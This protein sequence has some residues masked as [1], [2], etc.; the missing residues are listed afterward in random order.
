MSQVQIG[1]RK[2][3]LRRGIVQLIEQGADLEIILKRIIENIEGQSEQMLAA[4]FFYDPLTEDL[5]VGAAPHLQPSYAKAVNGFKVGPQQ[6]ACGSAV[7]RGE[8]VISED[9]R[10]D[11]LWK[12]LCQFA[13]EA[14][15]IAVWSEPIFDEQKLVLGTLAFYFPEPKSPDSSDLIILETASE[16]ASLAI[17]AR[18]H[19]FDLITQSRKNGL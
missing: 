14:K 18:R 12:N 7:F 4:I 13:E 1:T 15:I 10:V 2:S 16:L 3:L 17:Q 6:P 11:P 8:R 9:V 5:C 19:Q